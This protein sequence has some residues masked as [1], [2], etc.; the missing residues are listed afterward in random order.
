M[1]D[2]DAL[3]AAQGWAAWFAAEAGWLKQRIT[4]AVVITDNEQ[5][6]KH[7]PGALIECDLINYALAPHLYLT[8][9]DWGKRLRG[10]EVD[11]SAAALADVHDMLWGPKEGVDD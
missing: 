4:Q 6:C 7:D 9:A 1:N 11:M 8:P 2:T 3:I 10:L 5:L